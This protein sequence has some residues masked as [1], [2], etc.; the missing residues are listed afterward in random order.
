[1]QQATYQVEEKRID[2]MLVASVRMKGKYS[3]CGTGFAK[4]SSKFGRFICGK[5]MLLHHDSEQRVDDA[6]FE[7]VM[8]IQRGESTDEI[9]VR[10]LAGGDC[11]SLMHLGPYEE[12]GRSY[13]KIL[14]HA[15]AKGVE[16]KMPTR[17]IYHKGPGMIFR[18]NP[19]K[20][21]TEIQMMVS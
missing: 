4:I 5:P 19:K 7:V 2:P 13:E 15:K 20:Y 10:E 14:E 18:G 16:I 11:L 8:P 1:M 3:D 6:N 9:S 17:E 21:L 12:L